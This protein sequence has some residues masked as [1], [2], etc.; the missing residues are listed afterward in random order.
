[1][2]A[3]NPVTRLDEGNLVRLVSD[4]TAAICGIR[5]KQGSVVAGDA[6]IAAC[7]PIAG[8]TPI[9]VALVS[10]ETCSRAM[11][12]GML[13]MDPLALDRLLIEDT[14]REILNMVAGQ[15]KRAL[16]LDEALGL[17][18]IVAPAELNHRL[19]TGSRRI[20]LASGPL[21]LMLAL[22]PGTKL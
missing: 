1:M 15:V 7:L 16:K 13:Q 6:W 10:D 17:P 8:G 22:A 18:T 9:T 14:L 3:G 20:G 11:A 12:A 5:F 2:S 4:V 21:S 19:T